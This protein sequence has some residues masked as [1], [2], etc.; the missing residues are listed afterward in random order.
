M[1]VHIHNAAWLLL[2]CTLSVA[3]EIRIGDRRT[4]AVAARTHTHSNHTRGGVTR[5]RCSIGVE[6]AAWSTG[7]HEVISS[8]RRVVGAR[9][10]CLC[11]RRR[12]D[13][14]DNT[15]T[16]A[17]P[18]QAL[19]NST[20]EAALLRE[21]DTRTHVLGS[22]ATWG[23]GIAS[24][25]AGERSAREAAEAKVRVRTAAGAGARRGKK[26]SRA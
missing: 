21:G 14:G 16:R 1:C 15:Y 25:H 9:A 4:A 8:S 12:G 22:R 10:H 3:G 24:K 13:R 2:E 23:S 5:G 26:E 11:A 6:G 19:W 7:R 20:Y 18:G 17:S